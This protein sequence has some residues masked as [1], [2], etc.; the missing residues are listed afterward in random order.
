[1]QKYANNLKY[2]QSQIR[3]LYMQS[4]PRDKKMYL[5][6]CLL[7]RLSEVNRRQVYVL[8]NRDFMVCFLKVCYEVIGFKTGSPDSRCWR[9]WRWR[10]RV[11]CTSKSVGWS[12]FHEWQ[13]HTEISLREISSILEAAVDV[14]WC[15]INKNLKQAK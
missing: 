11:E 10:W 3:K 8:L 9:W 1:M 6:S 2:R 7:E 13:K 12:L 4:K 15:Y 14:I 5:Y